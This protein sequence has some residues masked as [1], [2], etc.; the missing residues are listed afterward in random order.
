MIWRGAP[1]DLH[2]WIDVI[3]LLRGAGLRPTRQRLV[4]GRLLFSKGNRH[5]TAA[6]LHDETMKARI[7]MSLA[8][9]YNTLHHFTEVGL[10]RRIGVSGT[11]AFFDTNP[12][13]HHHFFVE[14]EHMLFDIPAEDVGIDTLPATPTGFDVSGVD[15]VVRLKRRPC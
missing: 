13:R 1:S 9:V 12:S 4:L 3:R 15:V 5:V 2:R 7:P 14:D 11:I 8:T 10:L 6:M